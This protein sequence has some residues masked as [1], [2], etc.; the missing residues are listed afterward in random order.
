MIMEEPL[1]IY[2]K[3][4]IRKKMLALRRALSTDETD[5]MAMCLRA[6]IV[7]LPQYKNR[8]PYA[9]IGPA[10][11]QVIAVFLTRLDFLIFPVPDIDICR[12]FRPGLPLIPFRSDTEKQLFPI[13]RPLGRVIFTDFHICRKI[14]PG[15]CSK[16]A[17]L[18]PISDIPDDMNF[19]ALLLPCTVRQHFHK[20]K[21]V[22]CPFQFFISVFIVF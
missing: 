12:N 22:V 16:T 17:N 1:L 21:P 6:N 15:L 18:L 14:G 10:T 2:K 11:I 20:Q 3:K 9:Q 19:P 7:S 8:P 13:G 4:E 5:K